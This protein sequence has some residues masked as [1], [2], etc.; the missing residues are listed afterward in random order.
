MPLSPFIPFSPSLPVSTSN[1]FFF[2]ALSA[3]LTDLTTNLPTPFAFQMGEA[4]LYRRLYVFN[5]M[6]K[7]V[8]QNSFLPILPLAFLLAKEVT[9]PIDQ[10]DYSHR[11]G[12]SSYF[13]FSDRAAWHMG[14]SL[15][16]RQGLNPR[17]LHWKCSLN[18]WTSREVP[19][20]LTIFYFD[21]WN[22]FVV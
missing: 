18:H 20:P 15:V 19:L 12:I 6:L 10:R 11:L 17:P 9:S 1:F 16:S 2:F 22:S 3:G 8:S 13:L 7:V 21:V 14:G 4:S 5:P